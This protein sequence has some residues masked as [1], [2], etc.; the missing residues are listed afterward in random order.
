MKKTEMLDG[1]MED[2]KLFLK[3]EF[4]SYQ[5]GQGSGFMSSGGDGAHYPACPICGGIDPEAGAEGD[6]NKTAIGHKK[7]CRLKKRITVLSA[8]VQETPVDSKKTANAIVKSML[9]ER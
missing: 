9:K 4:C 3:L 5:Q 6:F 7:S 2:L 1:L 8:E